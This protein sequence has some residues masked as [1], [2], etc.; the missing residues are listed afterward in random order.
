MITTQSK[1]TPSKLNTHRLVVRITTV[2]VIILLAIVI[3]MPGALRLLYRADAQVALGNAKVV[4]LAL[5]AVGTECYGQDTKFGDATSQGGVTEKVYR[6]VLM[7][8]KAPG[9]FWVLQF[10]ED[11]CTVEKFI[12][13]EH[14]YTV[15][16]Q[17]NPVSYRVY[18]EESY[19]E[20]HMDGEE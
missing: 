14:E 10:G 20:T 12:Y 9:D 19:I 18:R 1:T 15:Y 17:E 2:L 4:R 5:Q 11:G 6:D 8:S 7:L 3:I 16:Y 13:R